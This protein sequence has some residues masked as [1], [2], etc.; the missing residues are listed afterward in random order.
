MGLLFFLFPVASAWLRASYLP[1]HVFCGLALLVMAIG[2]SLLGITEK[3]LFS[4]MYVRLD[5]RQYLPSR[6]LLISLMMQL[7]IASL[8]EDNAC[9]GTKHR[10]CI[11]TA[12]CWLLLD[13]LVACW[14]VGMGLQNLNNHNL[15]LTCHV[16]T[17]L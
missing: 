16:I 8:S 14:L 9:S 3:L 6:L 10:L 11:A 7:E 1:V 5:A 2:T 15:V 17:H 4:I 13:A 12:G